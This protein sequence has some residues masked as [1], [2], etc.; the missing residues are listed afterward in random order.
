MKIA[1][2]VQEGDEVAGF[3]VIELPGHA[4]GLIGL[5]RDSD[6]SPL[7]R[8]ASTRW[9]LRPDQGRSRVPLPAFTMDSEQARASIRKLAGMPPSL[10]WPG[11]PHP[12]RG[13]VVAQLEHAASATDRGSTQPSARDA[14][15][16]PGAHVGVP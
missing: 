2:T 3:R 8:T 9:T 4:P 15:L 16:A 6:G 1:G 13:D 10:V 14:R 7:Y 11:T 12:V 5:F